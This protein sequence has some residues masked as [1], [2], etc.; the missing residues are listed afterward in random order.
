MT[1]RAKI[2]EFF[3]QDHLALIRS[4]RKAKVIGCKIDKELAAKDYSV[5]V[6]YLDEHEPGSR[7]M[8]LEPLPGA[9]MIATPRIQT[10]QAVQQVIQE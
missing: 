1:S 9:V 3:A 8:D 7:V 6:V 10:E 4:S 2:N 5:S